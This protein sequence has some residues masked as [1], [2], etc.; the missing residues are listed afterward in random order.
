MSSA[1]HPWRFEH[2]LFVFEFDA[3]HLGEAV[4]ELKLL[5]AEGE[6]LIRLPSLEARGGKAWLVLDE[7]AVEDPAN[8]RLT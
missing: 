8:W 2:G 1:Y 7:A 4:R 5:F 3:P 6:G